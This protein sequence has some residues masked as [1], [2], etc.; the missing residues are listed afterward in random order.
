MHGGNSHRS[1]SAGSG[2][3]MG[4]PPVLPGFKAPTA[5]IERV[6][7]SYSSPPSLSLSVEERGVY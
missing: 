1:N 6:R 2:A 5:V 3:A 7:L 4:M